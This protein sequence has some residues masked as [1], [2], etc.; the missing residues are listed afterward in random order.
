MKKVIIVMVALLAL[1][2]TKVSYAQPAAGSVDD[3]SGGIQSEAQPENTGT[4]VVA[5][6]EAK[7]E[8]ARQAVAVHSDCASRGDL[9]AALSELAALRSQVGG[10]RRATQRNTASISGLK[11]NDARQDAQINHLR[12]AVY[13]KVDPKTKKR[14]GGLVNEVADVRK[15]T[16]D[17]AIVVNGDTKT[18]SLLTRIGG[19]ASLVDLDAKADK[20]SVLSATT[21]W[22]TVL[23][24]SLGL[25]LVGSIAVSA[26]SRAKRSG[27]GATP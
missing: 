20:A 18:P 23:L 10:E 4:P 3:M 19:K 25:V 8:A 12:E 6:V 7:V 11:A 15:K 16:D 14:S 22:V 1:S 13:G 27:G 9:A 26:L 21:F 5:Q 17:L 24:L 2:V